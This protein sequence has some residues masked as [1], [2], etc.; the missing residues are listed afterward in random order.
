MIFRRKGRD[1][2]A[3]ADRARSAVTEEIPG[4][5]SDLFAEIE[6][7]TESNRA[8]RD[9]DA[10][11]RLLRL[12]HAAGTRLLE[13]NGNG[14]PP[15]YPSPD[16]DRLPEADGLPDIGPGAITPELLRAGI[17]RD[18]SVLVRGLIG[19][20]EALRFAAGVERS[21][22]ERDRHDAGEP[23]A[24]GYY[25]E[26]EPDPRFNAPLSRPWI[27]E[28]GGVLAADSPRLC[29]EMLEI[30]ERSG[31]SRMARSYLGER[32]AI[33]A[34]KTTLRKAAPRVDG[35]WHQDGAFMTDVRALNVWVSLSRCGDEA[36]GLD[37]V[38]RRLDD[39]VA[40]GDE[41]G[42]LEF[43][44]LSYQIS[45]AGAERAAGETPIVRPNFEPGDVLLFDELCLHQTGSDPSMR[46]PR[47]AI[48]SWFFAASGFPEDYAPL[49][50]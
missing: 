38:P 20:D 4:D 9:R 45:Q 8:E 1:E 32:T 6:T 47:F 44:Y 48:E 50:V 3:V 49:A 16:F 40:S 21:C 13:G 17:L 34:Q 43:P 19:R 14:R 2:P 23:P 39:L 15:G 37:V 46:K 18:G 7:L 27:K 22:E 35:A 42:G 12:R 10:E 26:F 33:S 25:E 36:P 28:G 24:D 41:D 5:V 30:F 11:R 31:I 29:F